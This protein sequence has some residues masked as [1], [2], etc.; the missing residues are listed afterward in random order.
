V[1]YWVIMHGDRD[2][3]RLYWCGFDGAKREHTF[4]R[5]PD[6]AIRF[7]REQDARRAGVGL[8]K[9]STIMEMTGD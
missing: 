7:C 6:N 3:P 1:T 5:K 8:T 4:E 9:G 2:V